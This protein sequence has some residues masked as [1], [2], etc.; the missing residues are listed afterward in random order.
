MPRRASPWPGP[1][2]QSPSY[3]SPTELLSGVIDEAKARAIAIGT[4]SSYST[5]VRRYLEFCGAFNLQAWPVTEPALLH[6]AAYVSLFVDFESVSSYLSGIRHASL[7]A[8]HGW[9]RQDW[10]QLELTLRGLKNELGM[11]GPKVKLPITVGL[12][13]L[14]EPLIDKATHNDRLFWAASCVATMACLRGSE[15]LYDESR[16]ER[17]KLKLADLTQASG[18]ASTSRL[19]LGATKTKFWRTD[20][21][22]SL[23]ADGSKTCPV[24]ALQ[25]YLE[26]ATVAMQPGDFLFTLANGQPLRRNW[27]VARTKTLV[28]ACGLDTTHVCAA[29]W[30]SG[31]MTTAKQLGFPIESIKALSRHTSSAYLAYILEHPNDLKGI[32]L[33]MSK[34]QSQ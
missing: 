11:R 23:H 22:V 4:T 16:I 30:R 9:P 32:A 2:D 29:S 3:G 33:A 6:F 17:Q 20:V 34:L 13:R 15:F 1:L 10:H 26:K 27:M 18:I 24:A 12:L 14:F 5:A 25:H 21:T 28:E 31:G 19:C 8:G 7:R